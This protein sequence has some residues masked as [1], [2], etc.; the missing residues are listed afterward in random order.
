MPEKL[1]PALAQQEW[2]QFI[3]LQRGIL[4]ERVVH[5][6][7]VK[8]ETNMVGAMAGQRIKTDFNPFD[9]PGLFE[10][11]LFFNGFNNGTDKS[12]FVHNIIGFVFGIFRRNNTKLRF[13]SFLRST[14]IANPYAIFAKPAVNRSINLTAA[15]SA[16]SER[17]DK[18]KPKLKS[19]TGMARDHACGLPLKT[20][21]AS[22]SNECGLTA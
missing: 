15:S 17:G 19:S 7:D 10:G 18:P 11:G 16:F 5:F 8:T 4:E 6:N 13:L 3:E 9:A 22:V 2:L 1:V 14:G 12:D 21:L 20:S